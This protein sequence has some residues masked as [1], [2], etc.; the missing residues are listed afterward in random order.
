MIKNRNLQE[1]SVPSSSLLTPF[2][3]AYDVF[4]AYC[5]F[6]FTIDAQRNF[7]EDEGVKKQ[8][9][10]KNSSVIFSLF[11]CLSLLFDKCEPVS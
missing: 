5:K 1:V 8:I 2:V 4:T 6:G 10:V 9:G 7:L 3:S 11:L